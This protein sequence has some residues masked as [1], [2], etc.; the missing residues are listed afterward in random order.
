MPFDIIKIDGSFITHIDSDPSSFAIV[1]AI[2]EI[3]LAFKR[4]TVAECVENET[5]EKIARVLGIDY[6]QGFYY[7]KPIPIDSLIQYKQ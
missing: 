1:K 4:K 5:T 3:A 6:G 2:T 7:S